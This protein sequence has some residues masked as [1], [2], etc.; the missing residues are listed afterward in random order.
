MRK[1]LLLLLLVFLTGHLPTLAQFT[2]MHN[3][4]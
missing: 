4:N 2:E 1:I 3:G